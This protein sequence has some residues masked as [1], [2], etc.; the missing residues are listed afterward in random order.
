MTPKSTSELPQG[1][2]HQICKRLPESCNNYDF[3][4]V[5]LMQCSQISAVAVVHAVPSTSNHWACSVIHSVPLGF[6]LVK[7]I[8]A[9]SKVSHLIVLGEIVTSM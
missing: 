3:D 6:L 9:A 5:R 8:I 1:R 4:D 2:K 7:S